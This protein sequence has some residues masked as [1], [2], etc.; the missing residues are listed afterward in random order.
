MIAQLVERWTVDSSLIDQI[1]IGH[2]FDSHSRDFYFLQFGINF[3]PLIHSSDF[4]N[5]FCL[6]LFLESFILFP[7]H[8]WQMV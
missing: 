7:I 3:T 5:E 6:R 8:G 4:F 2:E 1:S